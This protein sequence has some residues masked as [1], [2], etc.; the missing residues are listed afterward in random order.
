MYC[1]SLQALMA[2]SIGLVC[3]LQAR[4]T[5]Q[6]VGNAFAIVVFVQ[7]ICVVGSLSIISGL[8]M[9]GSVDEAPFFALLNPITLNTSVETVTMIGTTKVPN[10]LL[11]TLFTLGVTR[12]IMLGAGSALQFTL[13]RE[14]KG[15]RIGGL[16]AAVAAGVSTGYAVGSMG[17]MGGF[18]P[19]GLAGAVGFNISLLLFLLPAVLFLGCWTL[20]G[21]RKYVANGLF[22]PRL[23]LIGTPAGALPYIL[24]VF[25]LGLA[26]YLTTLALLRSP[27]I[28][29]FWMRMVWPVGVVIFGFGLSWMA[30]LMTKVNVVSARR[31]SVG[32]GLALV[33]GVGFII[34][35]VA[36]VTNNAD[37]GQ[38]SP[39]AGGFIPDATI[40]LIDGIVLLVLGLLFLWIGE[41]GRKR[42]ISESY[43]NSSNA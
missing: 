5:I 18:G 3:A 36:Y 38:Y 41:T 25:G 19:A 42:L 7:V 26:S 10:I 32:L 20:I 21:E 14:L 27:M 6:A 17:R 33:F 24:T 43:G 2:G 12:L 15:L 35:I 39:F 9:G 34:S 11:A 37:I 31:A 22:K 28:P 23:M 8:M 16:I 30:S 40:S 4:K 29:E 13:S 1:L